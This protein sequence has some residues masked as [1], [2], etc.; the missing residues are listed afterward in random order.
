MN[1][2]RPGMPEGCSVVACGTLRAEMRRL[3]QAGFLDGDRLLFTAPGLHEWP[4]LLE[5]QL[6]RQLEKAR[7]AGG[8][9]IVAYGEKCYLDPET[10]VDTDGLLRRLGGAVGRVKAKNC[11]DML[12]G[13]EGRTRM[14]KEAKVYWLTPGWVQHWDFIFKDWD[15]AKANETF[16]ANDKA[17]VLDAVGYFDKA[18]RDDPE[19]I[20]RICD[21]MNLPLEPIEVSL[22]RLQSLLRQC[23][24]RLAPGAG[25]RSG[26]IPGASRKE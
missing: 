5:K 15:A 21:W 24:Q 17:I 18:S 22:E 26:T 11:V 23:A 3:A 16:P 10:G 14:A 1:D 7:T 2:E 13:A 20:L 12:V 4:G 6:T 19:R 25:D 9:V 8:P